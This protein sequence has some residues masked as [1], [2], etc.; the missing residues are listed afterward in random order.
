MGVVRRAALIFSLVLIVAIAVGYVARRAELAGERDLRLTTAAELAS[1][2]LVSIVDSISVA[3]WS[4]VD[5]SATADA[6]ARIHP[7]T[8]VCVV[9]A[10]ESSC[11]GEGPRPPDDVLDGHRT[12]RTDGAVDAARTVKVY[13]SSI[14]IAVD[15]PALSV[16]VRG[17]A[18]I[19]ADRGD[20]SAW[21]T[22]FLP[23]NSPAG[24]FAVEQGIRQTSA[25]VI[26]AR[27]VYVVAAGDDAI[28]VPE[29]EQRFYAIIFALALILLVLAG[30]TL[31]V[32]QRSLLERANFDPLTKL[33][34][35]SEFERRAVDTFAAAERSGTGASLLLFDLDGF[36]QVNDTYGHHVGDEMLKEIAARLRKAVRDDDVVARWGGDEFV[37]VMPG[38]DTEEMGS[39]RARQLAD[40]VGG[41]TRIEGVAESLRAK[42]SVGVAVWPD[43]G[44]LATLVRAAD[45]AMYQAKRDGIVCRVAPKVAPKAL[46]GTVV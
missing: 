30:I 24:G 11:A 39:R 15:G 17:P 27:G 16:I 19:V 26:G 20:I 14:T 33:P 40:A 22:T 43:H 45:H 31:V 38:V 36:K 6:V 7:R 32:E 21:A 29:D 23:S 1:S 12:I 28:N 18:D 42:V 46:V 35:R 9:T 37:V 10:E 5:P 2:R 25:D 13:D 4:G 8:G 3:A 34:N 41:R 44:D